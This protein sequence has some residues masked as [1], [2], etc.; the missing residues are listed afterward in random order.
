MYLMQAQAQARAQAQQ[1]QASDH[2]SQGYSPQDT[3]G[4]KYAPP[5]HNV[6]GHGNGA[7]YPISNMSDFSYGLWDDQ[8]KLL[9][10]L[11]LGY[12]LLAPNDQGLQDSDF[13]SYTAASSSARPFGPG[14]D[15]VM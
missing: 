12:D 15:I 1:P 4:G 10:S 7:E 3:T 5:P 14:N 2:R 11:G 6:Y 9:W 13:P 8:D